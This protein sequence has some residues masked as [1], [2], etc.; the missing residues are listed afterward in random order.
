MF[1]RRLV[2]VHRWERR[3]SLSW[4]NALHSFHN[5]VDLVLWRTCLCWFVIGW[6]S[7]SFVILCV[8]W[9][10]YLWL[11]CAHYG[12]TAE[13]YLGRDKRRRPRMLLTDREE[14]LMCC[15]WGARVSF[16]R[17]LWLDLLWAWSSQH[18]QR[19]MI[20]TSLCCRFSEVTI[21]IGVLLTAFVSVDRF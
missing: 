8:D 13:C 19:D 21:D 11:L 1:A 4:H 20:Y 6:G 9:P 15:L 12:M 14:S 17:C 5:A 18:E 7:H 16:I 10:F 3:K 2:S